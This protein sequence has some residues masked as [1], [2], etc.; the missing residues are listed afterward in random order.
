[1]IPS[2]TDT[3]IRV[4]APETPGATP[5]IVML[6]ATIDEAWCAAKDRFGGRRDLRGQDVRLELADGRCVR[7]AGPNR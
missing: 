7:Y 3:R 4:V 1:M 2:T 5:T 6:C